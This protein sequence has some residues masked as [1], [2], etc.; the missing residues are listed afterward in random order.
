MK[1]GV[2][3]SALRVGLISDTHD[4]LRPEAADFL[5]GSDHI[6]HAGD[7][8]SPQILAQLAELAPVTAVRGNNDREP[9]ADSLGETALVSLGEV[10]VYAIHDVS[11]L[12]IEALGSAAWSSPATRTSRSS[13]RA[14]EFCS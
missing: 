10:F 9:W 2:R 11:Q 3:A 1:S 4:L 13:S 7:I 6:I 5:R 12:D 8:C 14:T